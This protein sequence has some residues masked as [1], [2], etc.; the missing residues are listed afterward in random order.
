MKARRTLRVARHE[1]TAKFCVSPKAG[2]G[3]V[4]EFLIFATGSYGWIAAIVYAD[5]IIR[6]ETDVETDEESE[7]AILFMKR[8]T[9]FNVEQIDGLPER[10]Y[11]KEEPRRDSIQRIERAEAFFVVTGAN[12]RRGANR[13]FYSCTDDHMQMPHFETFRDAESHIPKLT[14][15]DS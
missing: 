11:T 7:H 10:F 1:Q 8:Y 3:G 6:T 9:V 13:A 2:F 4:A 14:K 12:V 5:K 15:A